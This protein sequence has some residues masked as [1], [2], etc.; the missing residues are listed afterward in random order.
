MSSQALLLGSTVLSVQIAIGSSK[1]A[2][3]TTLGVTVVATLV[4]TL[5]EQPEIT[6]DAA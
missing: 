6:D 3:L 5:I 2:L 1:N 4:G